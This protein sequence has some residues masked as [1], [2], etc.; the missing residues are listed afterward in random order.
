MSEIS[1]FTKILSSLDMP[2]S[3]RLFDFWEGFY[4]K[5]IWSP[6]VMPNIFGSLVNSFQDFRKYLSLPARGTWGIFIPWNR[7]FMNGSTF[8]KSEFG[9]STKNSKLLKKGLVITLTFSL[10]LSLSP[11]FLIS[12]FVGSSSPSTT[13]FVPLLMW[14][15][16]LKGHLGCRWSL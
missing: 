12:K 9:I 14:R 8:C 6:C 2:I 5:G 10:G 15:A 4:L 16:H 11:F 3:L 7:F 1:G 13:T